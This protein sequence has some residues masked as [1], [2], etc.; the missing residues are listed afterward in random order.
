MEK[1]FLVQSVDTATFRK[2]AK[3]GVKTNEFDCCTKV[4][5]YLAFRS[6]KEAV[7]SCRK[8][9]R[10]RTQTIFFINEVNLY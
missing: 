9:N 4:A 8:Y 3:D 1:V 10:V 5:T 7:D 6:K 2:L